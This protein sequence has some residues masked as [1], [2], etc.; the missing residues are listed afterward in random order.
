MDGGVELNDCDRKYESAN[1]CAD[2]L[3]SLDIKGKY[4]V[5]CPPVR[6][7]RPGITAV[8]RVIL[9]DNYLLYAGPN[10]RLYI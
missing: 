1:D 7:P 4:V 10:A 8:S 2:N 3:S 9:S 6:F 5:G